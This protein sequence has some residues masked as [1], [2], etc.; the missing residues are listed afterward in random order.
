MKKLLFLLFLTFP[1]FSQTLFKDKIWYLKPA[2]AMETIKQNEFFMLSEKLKYIHYHYPLNDKIVLKTDEN[3]IVEDARGNE[4]FKT[5][6]FKQ[7]FKEK[8]DEP[9]LVIPYKNKLFV[10]FRD[11]NNAQNR[12]Y[13]IDLKTKKTAFLIELGKS[14]Y[15][16]MSPIKRA[17]ALKDEFYNFVKEYAHFNKGWAFED[18][19]VLYYYPNYGMFFGRAIVI[20]LKTK[21]VVKTLER[22]DKVYGASK[23]YIVYS[24]LLDDDATTPSRK[25]FA[26]SKGKEFFIDDFDYNG[27]A[28]LNG[29][30]VVYLKKNTLFKFNLKTKKRTILT[31]IKLKKPIVIANSKTGNRIFLGERKNDRHTVFVYDCYKK[32]LIKIVDTPYG[33]LPPAI[34]SSFDGEFNSFVCNKSIY[35]L[36]LNDNSAPY[37]IVKTDKLYNGKTFNQKLSI[38]ISANDRCFVSDLNGIFL[39]GNKLK[40]NSI[41]V[42]LK[43]EENTFK[44]EA[45][46]NAGN[47]AKKTV[48][49][50]YQKPVKTGIKEIDK[51][52]EK[53]KDKFVV[54]KGFAW[55]WAG[56]KDKEKAKKYSKLPF[57]KNN[58]GLTRSDG[59]F[60]DGE[61][62][63]LLPHFGLRN[64]K[65]EIIGLVK[66]KGDKW[67][68]EPLKTDRKEE[69]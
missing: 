27:E 29:N 56:I 57:A 64:G 10:L 15:P 37:L 66:T 4:I 9:D 55:G 43:E 69:N 49:V 39:N 46:D 65:V 68:L 59:S 53:F 17:A 7:L 34:Y 31:S 16:G 63:I 50:F 42:E 54:L 44:L 24:K 8:V 51:N 32:K 12:I 22:V 14:Y 45:K 28:S 61:M 48:K 19:L 33:G 36:Y 30:V 5:K 13:S 35:R 47:I 6:S 18:K 60:S 23:D 21:S 1:L 62:A 58:T 26:F 38:K 67:Y 41:K 52:P 40:N 2:K 11:K 3:W 25:I 20:N